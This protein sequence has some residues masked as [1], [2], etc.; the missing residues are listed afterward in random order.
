[1]ID[2]VNLEI[3]VVGQQLDPNPVSQKGSSY[4]MWSTAMRLLLIA[5]GTGGI[6]PCVSAFGGDQ[7]EFSMP[8]GHPKERLRRMKASIAAVYTALNKKKAR[9]L[10]LQQSTQL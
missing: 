5:V 9:K 4:S 6:K 1:M 2:Y 3:V 7:I 8:D 10:Q